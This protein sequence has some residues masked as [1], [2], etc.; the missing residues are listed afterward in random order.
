MEYSLSIF[1]DGGCRGN[2]TPQAIGAIGVVLSSGREHLCLKQ[3]IPP[4][5]KPTSQRAELEATILALKRTREIYTRVR[6]GR[7]RRTKIHADSRYA[8]DCMNLW[9]D[10]WSQCGWLNAKGE[11]VV[12]RDLIFEA[13]QLRDQLRAQGGLEVIWIPRERNVEADA[14]CNDQ[15][16]RQERNARNKQNRILERQRAEQE[17]EREKQRAKEQAEQI[18]RVQRMKQEEARQ[19]QISATK[20]LWVELA[21]KEYGERPEW[22]TYKPSKEGTL[23]LRIIQDIQSQEEA[24]VLRRL[25]ERDKSN[26]EKLRQEAIKTSQLKAER[27]MGLRSP[28][29]TNTLI[30]IRYMDYF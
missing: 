3:A 15:L 1:V 26:Q 19:R 17:L 11:L 8:V 12:N 27:A 4:S 7:P 21:C 9:C 5:R 18:A 13:A 23:V 10:K 24:T 22:N 30:G 28:E 6:V 20:T 29:R 2:G 25:M 16:D 14:L